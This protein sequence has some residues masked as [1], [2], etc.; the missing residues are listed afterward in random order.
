M[1]KQVLTYTKPASEV[2]EGDSILVANGRVAKVFAVLTRPAGVI[3]THSWTAI[4]VLEPTARP[5]AF[6]FLAT[7]LILVIE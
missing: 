3:S 4:Q 7:D 1:K 5:S 2:K 6:S